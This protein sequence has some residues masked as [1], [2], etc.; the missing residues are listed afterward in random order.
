MQS[1]NANYL[2]KMKHLNVNTGLLMHFVIEVLK[3]LEKCGI[4]MN[5]PDCNEAFHLDF[6]YG[7]DGTTLVRC[8]N[9]LTEWIEINFDEL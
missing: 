2:S 7:D 9:C 5:C 6:A 1:A 3:F 4:K 8:Q